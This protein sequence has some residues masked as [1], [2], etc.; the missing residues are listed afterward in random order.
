MLKFH[1]FYNILIEWFHRCF[2]WKLEYVI[3]KKIKFDKKNGG[4]ENLVKIYKTKLKKEDNIEKR[5]RSIK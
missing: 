4:S 1:K 2:Y 3:N 5:R